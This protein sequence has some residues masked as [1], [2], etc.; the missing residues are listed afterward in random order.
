M[1]YSIN[2][3]NFNDFSVFEINKLEGRGYAIPYSS[4]EVL[5]KTSLKKERYSSDIVR[6]LSGDWQFKYYS[7]NNNLPDVIDTET[8]AFDT[9]KIPS[10]W[11]RN[12]YDSPAYINCPYAFDDVPPYVPYEQ[13]VGIYRKTFS[14]D[15]LNKRYIISFLGVV[16][17]LDLYI[18]GQFVGYSEG[19]H[20]TAEFDL[21]KYL[22]EGENEEDDELV[23]LE[24]EA[25]ADAVY[26]IFKE[27]NK[28]FF[29]FED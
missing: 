1:K 27:R 5:K 28:D 8:V 15:N 13:P 26:E 10:T 9:V 4:V 12:G 22:V 24:D 21:P 14:I 7:T 23:T 6:V 20:N 18:N 3:T 11:Q 25:V 2:K 17:C 16:S 29:D 19:A